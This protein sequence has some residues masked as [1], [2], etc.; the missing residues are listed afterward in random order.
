MPV[1]EYS[2]LDANGK[3]VK[4]KIDAESIR[5]ARQKLRSLSLY[6][7]DIRETS[8]TTTSSTKDVRSFFAPARLSTK[9]LAVATRQLSTLIGAGLPLVS[10]LQALSEQTDSDILQRLIIDI[11]ERVE[12]G[13]ALHKALSVYPK[14]FPRL[15]VNMV[16]A[17]EA[18]G[19][20]DMV[21]ENLAH[22]LEGQVELKIRIRSA[23]TYPVLM[24]AV[25]SLVISILLVFV[26]PSIVEMF[27]KQNATLPLPTE[28]VIAISNFLIYQ[29]Y[30]IVGALV[31]IPLAIRKYYQQPAGKEN[32]D[33]LLLKLPIF[34]PIYKKVYTA[35]ISSTL[36]TLLGSGV[37]L[38]AALDIAEK[39]MGNIHVERAIS[40]TRIGVREGK[41]FAKEL[42]RSGLFPSLLCHM[43]AIGEKSGD[44]EAMLEKAGSSYEKEVN[45]TLDGL[46]SILEPLLMIVVG[47]IVLVIV[48]SVLMPMADLIDVVQGPS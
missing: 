29:W 6:P 2:A 18:S 13:A 24:L 21:L 7:T 8:K 31:L 17:G 4:G 35:R 28:I 26:I 45:T 11:R 44:L 10:S 41:S 3:N 43:V 47:S 36:G 19:T 32:I 20:L 22:Y 48:I 9:D 37:Q 1:F 27:Q 30:I 42:A 12:E 46:T 33:R 39:L 23:L 25:C 14:S 38:L 5:T 16:A 40:E 34:G 15:Y